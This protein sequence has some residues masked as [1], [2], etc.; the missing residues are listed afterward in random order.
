VAPV[1]FKALSVTTADIRGGIRHIKAIPFFFT[2]I[3]VKAFIT[4]TDILGDTFANPVADT[5]IC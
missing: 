5:F 2:L 4:F 3:S 1:F